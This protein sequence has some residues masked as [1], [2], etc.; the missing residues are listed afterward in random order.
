MPTPRLGVVAALAALA[1]CASPPPA[2]PGAA[3]AANATASP[4]GSDGPAIVAPRATLSEAQVAAVAPLVAALPGAAR[5]CAAATVDRVTPEAAGAAPFPF[6]ADEVRAGCADAQTT[7]DRLGRPALGLAREATLLAEV[8]ARLGDDVDYLLRTLPLDGAARRDAIE[9]LQGALRDVQRGL[10]AWGR[11]TPYPYDFHFGEQGAEIGRGLQNDDTEVE[12]CDR[13]L[14]NLVFNQ[15]L[16]KEMVRRRMLEVRGAHLDAAVRAREEALVRVAA[17][18]GLAPD[19]IDA[20]RAYTARLRAVVDTFEATWRAFA[21]GA[22]PDE[23]AR[24]ARIAAW[25]TARDAW[26]A[27]WTVLTPTYPPPP[28]APTGPDGTPSP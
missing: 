4:V 2:A 24:A 23:A 11:G 10:D 22:V 15:G 3:S 6:T 20:Q 5:A 19:A 21:D 9:H 17:R 27:S 1:A 25:T 18:G 14:G 16:S 26:R 13:A 12:S 7:Y 8:A 28:A